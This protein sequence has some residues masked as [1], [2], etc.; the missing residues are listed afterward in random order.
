VKSDRI[1][2]G[3]IALLFWPCNL[4]AATPPERSVSPSGQFIIY[5]GD[6]G[7]RSAVSNLAERTKADVLALLRRRDAWMMPV[8][9][10]LQSRAP[11]LP[12]APASHLRFSQ[13]GSGLKLQLDLTLSREIDPSRI[14]HELMRTILLEMIYRNQTAIAPGES[15]VESPPWLIEGLLASIS[16]R[17]SASMIEALSVTE[18]ITSLAQFLREQ[19]ELLDSAGRLLH[20]AYSFALVQLLIERDDGRARLGRYIDNLAFASNNPMSDLQTAFPELTENG[21]IWK[22]K[23]GILRKHMELLSFSQAE[24]KLTQ[25]LRP[26]F[27]SSGGREK[28]LSFE[29]LCQKKLTRAEQVA[30]QKFVQELVLLVGHVNPVLRPVFE[31]YQQIA[32]RLAFG[33]NHGAAARLAELKTLRAEL[34]ARMSEIDDYLNWFE[35]TQLRAP[36]GLFDDYLKFRAE[37][38]T[39]SR[40]RKDA[41]SLYL[42]AVESE[43]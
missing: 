16:N 24:E 18:R 39:G 20:L 31:D 34:V 5:G 33:Q 3:L 41:L 42:D 15:Y 28:L 4:R 36:S 37:A 7:S 12:E 25:L 8:V 11:N 40:H 26:R 14:E 9:I 35:A 29:D 1:F 10:N 38:E 13:T 30:L 43:L 32:T 19:P 21:G 22:S 27:P 2:A 23:I 6:T 17:G